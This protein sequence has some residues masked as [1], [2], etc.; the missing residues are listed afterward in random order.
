MV[1]KSEEKIKLEEAINSWKRAVADYQNLEKRINDERIN[2]IRSANKE[3]ILRLLPI[4]DSL[5]LAQKHAQDEG[6][7]LSI[8]QFIS[9]LE[10]EGVKKIE[11]QGKDFDPKTMECVE[12]TAGEEGKVIEELQAGYML[13][14]GVLRP[15]KVKVGRKI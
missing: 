8:K 15:G 3:L 5:I 10:Q 13:H 14:D 4:L 1:K 7:D 9:V 12:I 11:T 2:W 6:A